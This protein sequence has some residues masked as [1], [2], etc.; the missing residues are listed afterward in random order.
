MA[1]Y[2]L[3]QTGSEVQTALDFVGL[4]ANLNTTDKATLVNAINEVLGKTPRVGDVWITDTN[5]NPALNFGGTWVLFDKEFASTPMADISSAITPNTT[6][7]NS[8]TASAGRTDHS[9]FFSF[10]WNNKV[11]IGTS[12]KEVGIVALAQVGCNALAYTPKILAG[13]DDAGGI[14][15]LDMDSST[16]RIRSTDSVTESGSALPANSTIEWTLEIPVHYSDMID[17]FCNKFYW[18]RTA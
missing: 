10:S 13:A 7:C 18:R 5:T 15:L 1:D 6:N 3:T 14:V 11:T 2:T 12:N 9:I 4:S 16:G 8:L 17:S